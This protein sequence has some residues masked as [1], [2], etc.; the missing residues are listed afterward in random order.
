MFLWRMLYNLTAFDLDHKVVLSR[1]SNP[2]VTSQARGE[3]GSIFEGVGGS[4]V[5]CS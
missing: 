2:E 5:W 3:V 1:K 4:R